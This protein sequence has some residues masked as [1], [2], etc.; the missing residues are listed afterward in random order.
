MYIQNQTKLQ[1]RHS[2]ENLR[3]CDSLENGQTI[4]GNSQNMKNYPN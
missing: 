1:S 4:T 2:G 3:C